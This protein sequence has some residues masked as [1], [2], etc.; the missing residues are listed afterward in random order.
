MSTELYE[1]L[2]G[3][4]KC[5]LCPNLC[6]LNEE[7]FGLCKTRKREGD[8][9]VNPYSGIIS[10][11]GID[12]IE[13][14]PLYHFMPGS[15]IFSVGF[16]GCTLKCQFC[17]NYSISQYH[18]D[19]N[20]EKKITPGEIVKLLLDR[21]L[22]SIAFTYS[23]PTLYYE[24]VKETSILCRKNNI[25]TVLVTNGYLNEKPAEDLLQY[26]D[27]AN[28]DLKSS[29][30]DFYKKICRGKIEPV[31]KFI[32]IAY[33]LNVHIELTT[34]IVTD[35]NDSIEEINEIIDFIKSISKDIPFHLSRYHPV[36]KYT[37]PP[38]SIDRLEHLIKIANEK[39]SYVYGGNMMG[40]SDTYC[41]ECNK[42][43]VKRNYYST[44]IISLD[45]SGKCTKCG[46]VN[47]FVLS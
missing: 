7:Q 9:I 38:T 14:K 41:K 27:A 15:E 33:K 2:N 19:V 6:T 25:K 8:K 39:L 42:I 17:Q 35:T 22:K 45:K 28:I 21:G 30:D 26:I 18:P 10:S 46:A 29:R 13:K 32:K 23:E 44:S 37:K 47:N 12:P 4:I 1:D 20:G 3:K 11:S 24:W 36:Y 40:C 16:F 5:L 31:K 34:L 43:L